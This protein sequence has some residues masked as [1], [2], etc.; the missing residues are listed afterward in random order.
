[1]PNHIVF[2]LKITLPENI[3]K[4]AE[5]CGVSAS[6]F[7]VRI[8]IEL[9]YC[10]RFRGHHEFANLLRVCV[11]HL[12]SCSRGVWVEL[13]CGDSGWNVNEQQIFAPWPI[14]RFRKT[15]WPIDQSIKSKYLC[16]TSCVLGAVLGHENRAQCLFIRK[17]T[18]CWGNQCLH[19]SHRARNML[20]YGFAL[21]S[22]A[23]QTVRCTDSQ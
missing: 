6:A 3:K 21:I 22:S 18:I 7:G 1:M 20:S 15:E 5:D 19:R 4:P 14:P 9:L 13:G 16:S 2:H 12:L 10:F 8:C 17:C 11:V 23:S